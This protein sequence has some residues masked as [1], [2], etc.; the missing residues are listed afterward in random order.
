MCGIA[1]YIDLQ[2]KTNVGVLKDMT[3]LIKYRGPDDEGYI[4][5]EKTSVKMCYGMDSILNIKNWQNFSSIY[6][7]KD[8]C[9]F[10]GLGHRRLSIID[11]SENGHQPMVDKEHELFLS[12]NGEIYNYLEIKDELQKKGYKFTTTSDS[13]VIL[14][15]YIE[16]GG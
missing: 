11:L 10:M 7:E 3:D 2:R 4:L 8:R 16:W 13:E 9:Y 14:K 5:F 15:A 1:G 6:E 12:Y